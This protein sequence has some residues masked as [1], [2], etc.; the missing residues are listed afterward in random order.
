MGELRSIDGGRQEAGERRFAEAGPMNG[1][2][3]RRLG[4][5][6]KG[7]FVSIENE[8]EMW[9]RFVKPKS[10]TESTN[11]ARRSF[12]LELP[13]LSPAAAHKK[14]QKVLY[15]YLCNGLIFTADGPRRSKT[16]EWNSAWAQQL[17]VAAHSGDK[18]SELVLQMA[19]AE[20]LQWRESLPAELNDFTIAQLRGQ[21]TKHGRP[22]IK[23]INAPRDHIIAR[24][25]QQVMRCSDQ[26]M[27]ASRNEA[28]KKESACSIVTRAFNLAID[29]LHAKGECKHEKKLKE[30][31]VAGIWKKH[32][33]NFPK[34]R[35]QISLPSAQAAMK[36]L[37]W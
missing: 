11:I 26:Q 31:T 33:K 12:E 19:A 24:I 28:T 34:T 5:A 18:D 16:F 2:K 15:A 21:P 25:V 7:I 27:D 30:K 3:I 1:Y 10:V 8:N 17:I 4:G 36:E 37:G 9:E 14:R 23:N 22:L 32:K 35:P 13:T 6:G 20:F 29:S